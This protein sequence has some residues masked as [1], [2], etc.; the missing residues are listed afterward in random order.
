MGNFYTDVIS[1]DPRFNSP[2]LC[3]DLALLEPATRQLAEK[4][5]SDAAAENISLMI[6]ETYRSQ[7]RQQA[8]FAKGS[9][10]LKKVGVHHYGLACDIVMSVKGK[11]SWE[12]KFAIIGRLAHQNKLI[13]GGDWGNPAIAHSFID[14]PHVQ[15]CTLKRQASLFS[16]AWYPDA[17]YDPY[18]DT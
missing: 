17:D 10:K 6:F 18:A 5:V 16:G 12:G 1:Q 8:L 11:P 14:Q 15:R 13:W 2:D 7:A 4:I 9:T 3:A